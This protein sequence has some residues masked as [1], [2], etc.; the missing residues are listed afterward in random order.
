MVSLLRE[1][2]PNGRKKR[3]QFFEK[4]LDMLI[5]KAQTWTKKKKNE[6]TGIVFFDESSD[7]GF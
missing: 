1:E 3:R 5:A 2:V 7:D 4:H 6:E